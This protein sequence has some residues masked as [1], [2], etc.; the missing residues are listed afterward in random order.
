MMDDDFFDDNGAFG[1]LDESELAALEENAIQTTQAQLQHSQFHWGRAPS[2]RDDVTASVAAGQPNTTT[3]PQVSRTHYQQPNPWSTGNSRHQQTTSTTNLGPVTVPTLRDVSLRISPGYRQEQRSTAVAPIEYNRYDET[4]ELWD[5]AAPNASGQEDQ[6]Y[7]YEHP[8][9][10]QQDQ[11]LESNVHEVDYGMGETG[12]GNLPGGVGD[13]VAV[14]VGN[15]EYQGQYQDSV[16]V[17]ALQATIK[18]VWTISL[19]FLYFTML[20]NMI[21]ISLRK[22]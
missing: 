18:E 5:T 4:A 15:W 7:N 3:R 13:R 14:S 17:Q 20:I 1:E 8:Q 2:Y 9:Q 11:I 19:T 6:Y 10:S 16:R 21:T 12:L 22:K